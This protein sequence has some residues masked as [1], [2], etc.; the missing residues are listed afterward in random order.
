MWY[1]LSILILP[2]KHMQG[3]LYKGPS[4]FPDGAIPDQLIRLW[5]KS[6]LRLKPGR[7]VYDPLGSV[8]M[9]AKN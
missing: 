6:S 5:L 2:M 3:W 7:L 8:Q 4:D 1:G 9:E